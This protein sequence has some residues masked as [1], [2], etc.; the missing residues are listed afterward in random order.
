MNLQSVQP[1]APAHNTVHGLLEKAAQIAGIHTPRQQPAWNIV[2]FNVDQYPADFMYTYDIDI[3]L[4][5]NGQQKNK[6]V[7]PAASLNAHAATTERTSHSTDV[8]RSLTVTV[9]HTAGSGHPIY[10][11]SGDYIITD[12]YPKEMQVLL[13]SGCVLFAHNKSETLRPLS[14]P[15]RLIEVATQREVWLLQVRLSILCDL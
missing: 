1:V 7:A 6:G 14:V 3:I 8:V 9:G 4:T 13:Q 12:A 2:S 15:L 5:Q 10:H 11:P